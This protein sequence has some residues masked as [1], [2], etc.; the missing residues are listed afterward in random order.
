MRLR[1]V[2]MIVGC[3]AFAA[4]AWSCGNGSDSSPAEPET[5]SIGTALP[6]QRVPDRDGFLDLRG[7][8][9]THSYFSHDACDDMPVIDGVR[10]E[11]CFEDLRRGMCQTR[12]DFMMFTDHPADFRDAQF[13]DALLFRPDR[14]DELV[15]RNGGPVASWAGCPDVDSILVMAGTESSRLMP[16]G[17]EGH[18]SDDIDER[19]EA[20]S[21]DTPANAARLRANG[22]VVLVAHPEGY[23]VDELAARDIDG[24]EMYNLHANLLRRDSLAV[25]LRLLQ[26]LA[27]N[28]PGLPHPD[29]ALLPIV[30]EDERYL[31]RWGSLLARGLRRVT[32]MGTDAHR[33]SLPT[34]MQDGERVD[35]FRRMLLWF[36]N[37]LLVAPEA[38]GS[39][40]DRHVKDALRS[41]RLYGAFEVLGY[42]SGFSFVADVDG[43]RRQMGE[44]VAL[45]DAPVLRVRQPTLRGVAADREAPVLETRILRAIEGGF[46]EVA[47]GAGDLA[48]SPTRPGAYRAEV[49]MVPYHLRPDLGADADTLLAR[50]YVWIYANPIYVE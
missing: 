50:D 26:R 37:H 49:R 36:S 39:W 18:I 6:S 3:A 30:V 17:L 22:A 33:N 35:S 1:S 19:A 34:L 8:I 23:T 43:E 11:P 48:Y 38:D 31:D 10:N 14:G 9:H 24:F 27:A 7:M 20:Y 5:W 44:E 47:S 25:A 45:A 13:S 15:E 4:V 2:T 28:D 16:V 12:H 40:D 46:E 42:P 21:S 32:T 41:G 29:L